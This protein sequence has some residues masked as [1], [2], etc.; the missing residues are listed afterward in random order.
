LLSIFDLFLG[1]AGQPFWSSGF[2]YAD[3]WQWRSKGEITFF[4]WY[5]NANEPNYVSGSPSIYFY[6]DLGW[7]DGSASS[8]IY[9]CVCEYNF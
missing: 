3:I 9:R 1:Y 6:S 8:E 2:K 7:Y 4:E 5:T